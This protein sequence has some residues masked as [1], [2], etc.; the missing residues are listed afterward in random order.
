MPKLPS[1]YVTRFCGSSKAT[2][3]D[4][5]RAVEQLRRLATALLE[6]DPRVVEV[7]LFGSLARNEAVP[8]S[9]ADVLITLDEHPE[10]RWF[11]RIPEFSDAFAS[12]DMPVEVFPYTREE[13]DHLD[14]DASGLARSA[15]HG[16]VLAA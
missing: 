4:R 7:R 3:L 1:V 2:Y 14:S 10:P 8:G 12:T 16:V 5:G 15:R 6:R 11:D 13:L 9:D